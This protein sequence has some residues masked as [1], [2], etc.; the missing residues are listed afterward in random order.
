MKR[1]ICLIAV[2]YSM[3]P[4]S[5]QGLNSNAID[6]VTVENVRYEIHK[7]YFDGETGLYAIVLPLEDFDNPQKKMY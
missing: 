3:L 2:I 1:I 5:S 7:S 6:V 4:S